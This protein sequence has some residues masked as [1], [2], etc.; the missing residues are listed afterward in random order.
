VGKQFCAAA[1]VMLADDGRLDLDEPVTRW[2]PGSR[3]TFSVRHLLSHTS[4][5]GHW[6]DEPGFKVFEPLGVDERIVLSQSPTATP[7]ASTKARSAGTG[8]TSTLATTRE[9][10]PSRGGCPRPGPRSSFSATTRH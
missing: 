1:F 10:S 2:Y 8:R 3:W 6:R 7:R 4:G 5:L 9:S